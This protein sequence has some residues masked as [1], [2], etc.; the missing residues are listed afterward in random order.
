VTESITINGEQ[1]S[2]SSTN[3]AGVGYASG[4]SA[5]SRDYFVYAHG[6]PGYLEADTCNGPYSVGR[7]ALFDQAA[8]NANI[9]GATIGKFFV[10]DG[11]TQE[12]FDVSL[13][14]SVPEPSYFFWVGLGIGYLL[15]LWRRQ[16]GQ[17]S[18]IRVRLK[19]GS[20]N[21]NDPCLI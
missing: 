2:V 16:R 6:G 20:V 7:G 9:A 4:F 10:Y 13:S 21:F 11:G 3:L 17:R 5:C 8:V 12:I 19:S 18:R 15:H 14:A 1:F